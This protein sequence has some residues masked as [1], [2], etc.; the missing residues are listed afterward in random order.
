MGPV[1]AGKE[2]KLQEMNERLQREEKAIQSDNVV[3]LNV[4]D[5]GYLGCIR[6]SYS[7]SR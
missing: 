4:Y 5:L 6:G 3:G 2:K 7:T 1:I